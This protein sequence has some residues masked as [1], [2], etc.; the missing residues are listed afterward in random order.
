MTTVVILWLVTSTITLIAC[1]A[2]LASWPS[3]RVPI[4]LQMRH[5]WLLR[6]FAERRWLLGVAFWFA[7]T[8]TTGAW[9]PAHR[10]CP[11]QGTR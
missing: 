2:S 9:G 6:A 8:V 10:G 4:R 7:A 11:P 5:Q 1:L 3:D